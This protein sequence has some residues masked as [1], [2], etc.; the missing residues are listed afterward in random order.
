MADI[1]KT[2]KAVVLT[3]PGEYEIKEVETPVPG[4]GEVL[5]RVESVAICGTDPKIIKGVFKGMWP[6]SY[7]FI[8]G[9]E[10]AGTVVSQGPDAFKFSEGDRIAGEAH[11]GCGYC[12]HCKTG[13]Y[14]ICLN[15]AK[16]ETGHRHYGFTAQGAYAQ[17]I[18]ASERAAHLM[19]E[20]ISF[21]E[22]TNVD[23]A[24]T[25][26]HGL[27]RAKITP[28]DDVAIFGPGAVGLLSV[29]FAKALGA[30]RAIMIGRKER[31]D[32]AEKLGAIPVNYEKGDPV[33]QVM[34]LTDGKG[35][36][37]AVECAGTE[38][39]FL[40]AI[41]I[42]EKGA[43]I[44]MN[45][46]PV[47]EISLPISSITLDE[48]DLIGVRA[49]PNTCSE[50]MPLLANGTIKIGPMITHTFPIDKFTE[51]LKVFSERLDG[52]IKVIIK[53]NE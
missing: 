37:V 5:A 23:T 17:Y 43:R 35:V 38:T 19:P 32:M 13:R 48:K 39:S 15:Y 42:T 21:D 1:P 2:M 7:P 16:T 34:K 52:A 49:D 27:K 20:N 47:K 6:K 50:L 29:Q 46:L 53:P 18:V 28:G 33:E 9:H 24:G 51:A 11:K 31:L 40:Q 30:G 10:W 41:K 22:G 25:A 45:G 14:T 26:L 3:G 44:V 12:K 4:P 8:I 36:Q